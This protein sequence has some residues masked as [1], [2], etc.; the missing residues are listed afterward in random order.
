M[1]DVVASAFP[2]DEHALL[3]ALS[4]VWRDVDFNEKMKAII[5]DQTQRERFIEKWF[6]TIWAPA[7]AKKCYTPSR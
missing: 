7:Q 6:R 4:E 2:A 3:A 1:W 5:P